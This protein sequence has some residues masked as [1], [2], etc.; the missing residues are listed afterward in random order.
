MEKRHNY[1]FWYRP[2]YEEAVEKRICL[3][4]D[5]WRGGGV[6]CDTPDPGGCALFRYLPELVI[7]YQRVEKPTIQSYMEAVRQ[8]VEMKCH[9]PDPGKPCRLRDTLDC[10][11]DQYIPL[12]MEAIDEVTAHLEGS[13]GHE[14][15]LDR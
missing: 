12:V 13:V 4:C 6:P 11:L 7:T 8:N 14:N 5:K 9:N 1:F 3:R 15:I 10:G 2:L